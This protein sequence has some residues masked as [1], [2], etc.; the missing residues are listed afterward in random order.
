MPTETM[1]AIIALLVPF[2]IFAGVLFWADWQ[3]R[4]PV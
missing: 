2:T 1:L 4:T 3:T